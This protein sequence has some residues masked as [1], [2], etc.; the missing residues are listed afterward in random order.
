MAFFS[1]GQRKIILIIW[2]CVLIALYI[3]QVLTGTSNYTLYSSLFVF[4][5]MQITCIACYV[6]GASFFVA[7]LWG[8][9]QKNMRDYAIISFSAAT[10]LSILLNKP[11]G[12]LLS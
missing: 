2:V 4:V 1:H 11:W 9:R 5:P 12:G 6:G 7:W 3:A 10:L 8:G